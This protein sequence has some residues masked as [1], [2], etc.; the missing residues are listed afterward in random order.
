MSGHRNFRELRDELVEKVGEERLAEYTRQAIEQYKAAVN[1]ID[2][3][4]DMGV[5]QG[6]SHMIVERGEKDP[7][8]VAPTFLSEHKYAVWHVEAIQGTPGRIY[9]VYNLRKP[10]EPQLAAGDNAWDLQDTPA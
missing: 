7:S 9:G 2:G 6:A 8:R 5:R 10:K 4:F 1:P 3:W